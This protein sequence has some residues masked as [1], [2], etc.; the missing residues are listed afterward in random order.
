MV[1]NKTIWADIQPRTTFI[2]LGSLLY[3]WVVTHCLSSSLCRKILWGMPQRWPLIGAAS[4]PMLVSALM[5]NTLS[6]MS[7]FHHHAVI[8]V[9]A[10]YVRS[11]H[12]VG[13]FQRPSN[14][15]MCVTIHCASKIYPAARYWWKVGKHRSGLN[16]CHNL[17]SPSVVCPAR[18]DVTSNMLLILYLVLFIRA[19]RFLIRVLRGTA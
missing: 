7:E 16:I 8:F 17:G 15:V 12:G 3:N 9:L 19:V 5:N 13:H 14:I 6:R 10:L 4:T 2:N 18:C 11:H 1:I